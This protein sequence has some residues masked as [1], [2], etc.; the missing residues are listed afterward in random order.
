MF[1]AVSTLFIVF[2]AL[3][4]W[5]V[6][7]RRTFPEQGLPPVDEMRGV[8]PA[9]SPGPIE[10]I[11]PQHLHG[12]TPAEGPTQPSPPR[13][14]TGESVRPATPTKPPSGPVPTPPPT[15]KHDAPP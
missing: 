14:G 2:T 11:E 6:G 12:Y 4:L 1:Y 7:K 13:G 3:F 5:E 8:T 15:S 10:E 9:N